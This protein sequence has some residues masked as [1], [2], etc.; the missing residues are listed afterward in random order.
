MPEVLSTCGF[1]THHAY[2]PTAFSQTFSHLE[3]RLIPS[4][5]GT[6]WGCDAI[7]NTLDWRELND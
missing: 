5:E 3:N 2:E 4:F 6:G 7:L 1:L